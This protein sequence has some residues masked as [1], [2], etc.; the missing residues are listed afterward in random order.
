M[1]KCDEGRGMNGGQAENNQPWKRRQRNRAALKKLQRKKPSQ[2]E[3]WRDVPGEKVISMWKGG[4]EDSVGE[5]KFPWCDKGKGKKQVWTN[6]RG[7]Q[8]GFSSIRECGLK[9][10]GEEEQSV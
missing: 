10:T 7:A 1:K 3:I 5:Q 8:K 4:G 9:M 6:I 2:L